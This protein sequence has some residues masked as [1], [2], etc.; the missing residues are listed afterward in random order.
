MNRSVKIIISLFIFLMLAIPLF[1]FAA[2][3]PDS[4]LIPCGRS[5]TN[6]NI[7]NPCDFAGFMELINNVIQFLLFKMAVP[8]AAIMFAYAGVLL[9]TAGGGEAK[10]KAKHI[11]GNVVFG[12]VIAIAAWLIVRTILSILGFNGSWI[13]F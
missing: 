10:T 9:V 4:G 3:N 11:F 8:I 6:G 2:E 7:T 5:D 1:S 13:G 12:L